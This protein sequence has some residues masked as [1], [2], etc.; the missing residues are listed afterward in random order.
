MTT[1]Q[2]IKAALGLIV[3]SIFFFAALACVL[4]ALVVPQ[5]G[6]GAL[7]FGWLASV[8]DNVFPRLSA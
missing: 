5:I 7:L 4:G 6:L 3:T 8:S 2:R 1:T